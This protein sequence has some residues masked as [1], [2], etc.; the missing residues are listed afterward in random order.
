[1]HFESHHHGTT[2]Q[3]DRHHP[4][5]SWCFHQGNKSVKYSWSTSLHIQLATQWIGDHAHQHHEIGA[6]DAGSVPE[7]GRVLGA[8]NGSPLWY[9]CLGNFKDN[10]AWWATA[11][12]VV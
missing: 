10:R 5:A 3:K 4:G 9:F 1:M 12:E 7:S 11:H 8:G 2:T 6:R